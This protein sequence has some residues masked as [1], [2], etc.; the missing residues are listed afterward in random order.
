MCKPSSV[1]PALSE[2]PGTRPFPLSCDK[3]SCL[4][5]LPTS[6][7]PSLGAEAS[8]CYGCSIGSIVSR[9]KE[10]TGLFTKGSRKWDRV[11]VQT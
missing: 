7:P 5:S 1:L 6:R 3:A 2:G 10:V 11:Q 4:L 8:M 9:R